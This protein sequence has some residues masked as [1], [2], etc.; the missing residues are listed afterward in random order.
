MGQ[1]AVAPPVAPDASEQSTVIRG[2]QGRRSAVV[3][4]TLP[5]AD[6][7]LLTRASVHGKIGHPNAPEDAATP[8]ED[9]EA[10]DDQAFVYD[11]DRL[12]CVPPDDDVRSELGSTG[13]MVVG[14]DRR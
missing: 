14:H 13:N 11:R 2:R 1:V 5:K 10:L 6:R 8:E 9:A 3:E 4:G 12:L 7:E